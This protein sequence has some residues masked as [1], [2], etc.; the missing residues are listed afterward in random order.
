MSGARVTERA[1][2]QLSRLLLERV[3]LRPAS[4]SGTALRLAVLA[5]LEALGEEDGEAYVAR[6]ENDAGGAEL[7]ALLPLVT[8]GKTEFFRDAVQ[9]RALR[10]VVLPELYARARQEM[11]RLRIWSAGC[12]TGEEAYSLAMA[13]AEM[14]LEPVA[15][16]ILATDVNPQAVELASRGRFT[17]RRVSGIPPELLQ[18]YFAKV[19]DDFEARD[20]LRRR[21]RFESQNLATPGLYPVPADGLPWDLI[22]CRNV[23][24]YFDK[25]GII[26]VLRRF[27]EHLCEGGYLCL[28]YSESLFRV[29]MEFELTEVQGSFLYRRPPRKA[30]VRRTVSK[31]LPKD[32]HHKDHAHARSQLKSASP[33]PRVPSRPPEQRR[34]PDV[35]TR[36]PRPNGVRTMSGEMAAAK[37]PLAAATALLEQGR[38]EEATRLLEE[39]LGNSPDNLA[40]LLTHGNAML[41]HRELVRARTDYRRAIEIEPLCAE[42]HLCD[43]IACAEGGDELL[44]EASRELGRAIFLDPNLALAH[45]YAGRVAERRGDPAG[46]RRAYRNVLE[47]CKGHRHAVPLL[48]LVPDLPAD[49][50]VLLRAARYSLAALEG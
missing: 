28:G 37:E 50:E 10:D 12:A 7:R 26:R 44:E 29:S 20:S 11:R 4:E 6:L 17:A 5:R 48:G 47:A 33:S 40:L 27:Y 13:V 41:V 36:P 3:G 8:V 1:L 49:P 18:R 19:G 30:H 25:A 35:I 9:F 43:G 34:P 21:L 46:A 15:S 16:D 23:L 24:I 14:G 42:A 2:Q 32:V 39:A 22:L 38:F 45:Y 31:E